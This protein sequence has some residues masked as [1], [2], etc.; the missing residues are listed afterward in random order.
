[1]STSLHYHR[2]LYDLFFIRNTERTV[3]NINDTAFCKSVFLNKMPRYLVILMRIY[4]T[5]VIVSR[6]IRFLLAV[7]SYMNLLYSI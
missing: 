7:Y 3:S 6:N 5:R 2:S 1:M 4:R